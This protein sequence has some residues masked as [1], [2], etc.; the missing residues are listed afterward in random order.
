MFEVLGFYKFIKIKSLKKNKDFIQKFLI[1]NKIRGTII[2]A[3]EGLNGTISGKNK[4]LEKQLKRLNQF[5]H[6]KILIVAIIQNLNFNL[7]TNQKLKLK[8]K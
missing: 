7:F 8:K 4:D 6:L 3:K 5:F 1:K 2:I